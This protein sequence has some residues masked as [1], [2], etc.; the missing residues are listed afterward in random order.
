MRRGELLGLK[1]GAPPT[2][3]S[4]LP[5]FLLDCTPLPRITLPRVGVLLVSKGLRAILAHSHHLKFF[6][7]NAVFP[8][9]AMLGSNQRPPPCKGDKRG[10]GALRWLA[11]SAYLS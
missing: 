8:E 6:L 7:Q 2:Q 4:L 5:E 10:C 1:W 3:F 9:W 11:K